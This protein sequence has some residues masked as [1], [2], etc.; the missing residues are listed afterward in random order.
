MFKKI[1]FLPF[2][3]V[4]FINAKNICYEYPSSSFT[5]TNTKTVQQKNPAT[6]EIY[7]K[8]KVTVLD[9]KKYR[10]I[11]AISKKPTKLHNHYIFLVRKK[12]GKI[13]EFQSFHCPNSSPN[14]K[15]FY[16]YGER[17]SGIISFE[18]KN[19]INFKTDG[20]TMGDS[21]DALEGI[22]KIKPKYEA[23]LPAPVKIE[24]PKKIASMNLAP[25][26][27]KYYIKSILN[28]VKP[29]KY[30]CYK[31]KTIS[32]SSGKTLYHGCRYSR[33]KCDEYHPG[34]K[35]FG[36]YPNEQMAL[37]AYERCKL[38]GKN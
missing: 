2:I 29:I 30:V 5:I 1:V 15:R 21:P 14:P 18:A 8:D 20:I 32:K 13:L 28:F 33:I 3:V 9:S 31:S 10:L 24:C 7:F 12:D 23:D 16:C 11:L 22:W 4:V 17:D 27:N 36:H 37:K 38:H 34:W 26:Y 25:R 35:K 6:G 19:E